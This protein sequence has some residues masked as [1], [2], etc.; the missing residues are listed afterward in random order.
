MTA[1][2]SWEQRAT[3]A[4]KTSL[5]LKKKVRALY[6]DGA[7]TA[8]HKQLERA[9]QRDEESRRRRAVMQAR[10]DELKRYSS[11]L[12]ATVAERTKA[13]R[14]ILDNVTFGFLVVGSDGCVRDGFTRSCAEL[15]GQPVE[16][17]LR[18]VDI[19]GVAGTPREFELELGLDQLFEDIMPESLSLD[20]L[21]GRFEVA[22]R[23]LRLQGR[24]IRDDDHE[25]SAILFT[26]SD[27]TA[28]EQAR[29]EA[30][31]NAVLVAILRQK[32]AF[33]AF[34]DDVRARIQSCHEALDDTVFVRRA[35]HTIK[36][37]AASYGLDGVAHAAHHAESGPTIDAADLDGV[38]AALAVFLDR[39]SA[40]LGIPKGRTDR[41]YEVTATDIRTLRQIARRADPVA[42]NRWTHEVVRSPVGELL[43]P[44][45]VFV[46]RLAERLDKQV[47]F[48]VVGEDTCVDPETVQPVLNN[49]A[50][51]I[52]NALD[53][54]IEA[55]WERG[56]KGEQ[57][58]LELRFGASQSGWTIELVDDGRGVQTDDLVEN[59]VERGVLDREVAAAM[60]ESE[61]LELIFV[62]GLSSR[63]EATTVSGRGVGMSAVRAAV[64][65]QG[66]T[67]SFRSVP[68]RGT[69]VS[70]WLPF[71]VV[72]LPAQEATA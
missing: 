1:S 11:Q 34:V 28:L 20:Q 25:V 2:L 57:G 51:L 15:L 24:V 14:D 37:N 26:L 70:V 18:L 53:H 41:R 27:V 22:E 8:I 36:G 52:R 42:V 68:G 44:M 33:V 39:H 30:R 55:A 23:V 29:Q 10:N 13:L 12:E 56:D 54:G 6:N 7:A 40:V 9:R 67:L 50:H 43:G 47:A 72:E 19:L 69:T 17:G 58:S 38:S 64:Q 65:E 4:E 35:V 63:R 31:D 45:A 3:A 46:D 66:G 71:P 16:E 61:R 62:D 59:A 49:L 5:I 32:S 60:T 21:P 48:R